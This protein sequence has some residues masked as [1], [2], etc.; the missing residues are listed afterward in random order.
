MVILLG[1]PA[2]KIHG[3]ETIVKL[4]LPVLYL[5]A[6]MTWNEILFWIFYNWLV[7]PVGYS[8]AVGA[9]FRQRRGALMGALIGLTTMVV[10]IAA[11]LVVG[12]L[13]QN[14]RHFFFFELWPRPF[15]LVL[16]LQAQVTAIAG[17]F[18]TGWATRFILDDRKGRGG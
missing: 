12:E 7:A 15:K 17:G 11:G 6:S 4:A 1:R 3:S 2:C 18:V 16:F 5:H 8:I 13:S 10:S 14:P 9:F